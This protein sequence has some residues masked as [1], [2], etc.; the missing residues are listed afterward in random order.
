M[1]LSFK[2]KLIGLCVFLSSVSAVISVLSY[3]GLHGVEASY[4]VITDGVMPNLNL[5]NDM[6][7]DYR[8]IRINLRSLGIGGLTKEEAQNYIEHVVSAI[9]SYEKNNKSYEEIPRRPGEKEIYDKVETAW[10]HFKAIGVNALKYYKENTP[11]SMEKLNK[12]FRHDCPEAAKKFT[13]AITELKTFHT[14]NGKK[15]RAEAQNKS[16]FTNQLVILTSIIGVLIG[17][18]IGFIFSS[19]VSSSITIV[20]KQLASN[21]DQVAEASSQIAASSQELSQAVTEQASSLEET[22]ASLEEITSMIAKA[23]DNAETASRSSTESHR[24]AEQGREVVGQ[25]L[26][27]MDEISQS[28]EAILTQINDSNRQMSEIVKVIQDIGNRTKVINEIVFQTK[29]L[30]FNASVEAARAGEQGKGFAVVAEEVGNLAQMSG[31]AAKEIT[32]MLGVSISKVEG[33]VK[34]TQQKV[35]KLVQN[36]KDKVDVGIA[37]AKQCSD[38]LNEIVQDVSTVSNL[39]QEISHAAKEQAQGVAEINKAMSQLDTVTQQNASSSEQT[40]SSAE[41]LSAQAESLKSSVAN[42]EALI[43]GN[44]KQTSIEQ[45]AD[46]FKLDLSQMN[47]SNVVSIKSVKVNEKKLSAKS[48]RVIGKAVGDSTIP[49]CDDEGFNEA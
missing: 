26:F 7:L 14:E 13:E 18:I 3:R 16:S 48:S 22:A 30:S 12:I 11:E 23:T 19:K 21:A 33:I 29:L 10:H 43:S 34:D 27:S 35:E 40:A 17:L 31:N 41:E 32:E 5:L 6:Y 49:N 36:G 1:N 4:D 25:M 38:L 45:K 20:A 37:V 39:S 8:S 9:E 24:K 44:R 42:L 47:N 46:D 15:F 2:S 28:N